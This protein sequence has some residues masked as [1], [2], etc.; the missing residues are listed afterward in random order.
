[1]SIV[2]YGTEVCSR[3]KTAK[4]MLEHRNIPFEFVTVDLKDEHELPYIKID[5]NI[6]EGKEALLEIRRM[7][8]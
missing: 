1:M 4:M 8:K 3:C 7:R 5:G 2:L 6:Y